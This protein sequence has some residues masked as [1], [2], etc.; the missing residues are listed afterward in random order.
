M[1]ETCDLFLY[2]LLHRPNSISGVARAEGG[3]LTFAPNASY[4]GVPAADLVTELQ[5]RAALRSISG[6]TPRFEVVT[7]RL[8]RSVWV[9]DSIERE[10][11]QSGFEVRIPAPVKGK[12]GVEH[13]F[14]IQA[15][16]KGQQ[17]MLDVEAPAPP[18]QPGRLQVLGHYAKVTDLPEANVRPSLVIVP[19]LAEDGRRLADAYGVDVIE[20]EV[21][22]QLSERIRSL[23]RAPA[24]ALHVSTGVRTLDTM[25]GGGLADGRIYLVLGDVGSGKT[26]LALQFL[27]AAAH[28]G[29]RGFF[30]TT[31]SSPADEVALADNL[32]FDLREQ[33]RKG[34]INILSLTD[35]FDA[36]RDGTASPDAHQRV[37]ERVLGELFARIQQADPKRIVIDTLTPF[38]PVRRYAEV[39]EF[40]R[41]LGRMNRLMIVTEEFGLDGGDTSIEE[42]FVT[43][44][45]VLHRRVLPSGEVERTVRVEKN[46]GAIHDT[47]VRGF[48]M[49][50]GIGMEV[51]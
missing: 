45:I 5:H 49:H 41:G 25:L 36:L 51:K 33:V 11:R 42:Y 6:K 40:I 32:G 43:G 22:E 27:L 29:E 15:R 20:A 3:S 14:D 8:P 44:V 16:G 1:S 26:T 35:A 7:N 19:R 24:A 30:V 28:R 13:H 48:R 9:L 21:P 17:L 39:R 31:N 46:R 18:S 38:V 12:S 23:V 47:K 4:L 37:S 10:L 34:M 2:E 50:R